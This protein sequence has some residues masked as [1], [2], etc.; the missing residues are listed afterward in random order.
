MK[1]K[2]TVQ[3]TIQAPVN[4]VWKFWNEPEHIKQWAFASDDWHAPE[5][6]NDLK[7]GGRFSTTMAAKDGSF[8]FE[9]GG[10]Y[11]QVEDN[12]AIRYT[13]D[14]GRVT[15]VSFES[16]N[17][18]TKVVEVFDAEDTNPVDMQQSGWQAIL[19]NFKKYVESN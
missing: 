6:S 2:V 13:M 11:D 19:D 5:A 8:S 7:V 17:G 10:V 14:D 15:E 1:T 3:S 4:K 18:A 12:K 9:F 16:E